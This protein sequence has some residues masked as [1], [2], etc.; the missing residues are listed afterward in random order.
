MAGAKW[1]NIPSAWNWILST[2]VTDRWRRTLKS[3]CA[4][5][6]LFCVEKAL[7]RLNMFNLERWNQGHDNHSN[8]IR[9]NSVEPRCLSRAS[10]IPGALGDYSVGLS[11]GFGNQYRRELSSRDL[12]ILL[13]ASAHRVKVR[14]SIPGRPFLVLAR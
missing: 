7:T 11:S 5:Y 1:R 4:P 10:R 6:H 14:T 3:C 13:C 8:R 9:N 12:A 2:F